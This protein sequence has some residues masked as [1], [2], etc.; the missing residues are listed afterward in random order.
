MPHSRT[1]RMLFVGSL[2]A[3]MVGVVA[4]SGWLLWPVGQRYWA[5]RQLVKAGEAKDPDRLLVA[6]E[7]LDKIPAGAAVADDL[8][9]L[10]KH[11][12]DGVRIYAII[13]LAAIGRFSTSR[14]CQDGRRRLALRD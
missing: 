9:V 2:V 11:P 10:A 1:F 13:T 12:D 3:A 4:L 5:V 6:V 14:V 7:A 8:L